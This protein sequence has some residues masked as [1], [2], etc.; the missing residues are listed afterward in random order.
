MKLNNKGFAI[1]GVLYSLLILFITLFIGI[2]T[3]LATTKFSLDKVKND[4]TDKLET[5]TYRD[6]ILNGADPVLK[7]GMI[8][9]TIDADGTVKKADMTSAWYDYDNKMWANAI[10]LDDN[11]AS[12][13]GNGKVNGATKNADGYVSFDGDDDY[14]NLGLEN[15]DFG[16]SITY[17][18]RLKVN[19]IREADR[20][21][22]DD[23]EEENDIFINNFE[24]AGGGLETINNYFSFSL[25]IEEL[26]EYKKISATNIEIELGKWYTLVGTYDGNIM[27][28][29]IDG[30]LQASYDITGNILESSV[31]FHLGANYNLYSDKYYEHS[32]IDVAQADIYNRALTAEEIENGYSKE[33]RVQNSDGLLKHVDFS[34]KFYNVGEIIPEDSIS[35][36]YTWIPRY[37]YRLWYVE[38][39]DDVNGYTDQTKVHS[40]DIVFESKSS[41]KSNGT[42]NGE[43]LTHPAFTLGYEELNGIWVGKFETGYNGATTASEAEVSTADSSKVIIKPN[44]Y[45]WRDTNTSNS[46][47]TALNM[48]EDEITFGLNS[49]SDTH[50]IKN[51]EWGAVTYLAFSDYGKD[52]EV[53]INNYSEYLTGCGGETPDASSS[54]ICL[55][56]YGTKSNNE[57]NQSTTGNITGIFDMSGGA[58]EYVMGRSATVVSNYDSS[59]FTDET[60][61]EDKYINIYKSASVLGYSNRIL[62]DATGEMGPF[63][64][65]GSWYDDCACFV[66]E[67]NPW[68]SRGGDY[69]A[70]SD[71]GLAYFWCG[72]GGGTSPSFRI[73]IS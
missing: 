25:W 43:Y 17:A 41:A 39:I 53:Y 5:L 28:L 71:A 12:L 61:P 52:S 32:N 60:F 45:S 50:I 44:T 48:N 2:L 16:N 1:S 23:F 65:R 14:I 31:P 49:D 34:N 58:K 20:D 73:V 46:F 7:E 47:Y 42:Q 54:P 26:G 13:Y 51:T 38:A 69:D 3:I 30:M 29:Y 22:T 56:G 68:F 11:Y 33:I 18:I 35:Q 27:K 37:K 6:T 63:G 8:P 4:I 64:R 15:Y 36:Y 55:N 72:T 10:V 9:V 66:N 21:Q 70:N 57:Y 40:I 59:G 62:G 19:S 67:S 24:N